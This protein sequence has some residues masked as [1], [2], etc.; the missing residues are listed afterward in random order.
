MFLIIAEWDGNNRPTKINNKQTQP[1][2]D[3]WFLDNSATYPNA[4]SAPDPGVD[5]RYVLVN[6]TGDGVIIDQAAIDADFTT[7]FK[8]D[9]AQYRDDYIEAELTF[10]TKTVINSN[11]QRAWLGTLETR[12]KAEN[13]KALIKFKNV[14]GSVSDASL[15]DIQGLQKEMFLREQKGREAEAVV[16][17][18]HAIT[19]YT[20]DSWKTDFDTEVTS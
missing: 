18:N 14:N 9:L 11:A 20:D 6:G 1:E 10:N 13:T 19:P 8:A 17:A 4:F 12:W 7:Q 15:S 3:Q 2:V 16:L 5:I